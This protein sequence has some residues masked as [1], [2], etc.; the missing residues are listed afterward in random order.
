[1]EANT[2]AGRV[3]D[4]DTNKESYNTTPGEGNDS[5]ASFSIQRKYP[6]HQ[7]MNGVLFVCLLS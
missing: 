7:K 3:A 2:T 4:G 6:V 5:F 1:M